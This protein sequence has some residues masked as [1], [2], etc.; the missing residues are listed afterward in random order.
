MELKRKTSELIGLLKL[1]I[2]EGFEN[3]KEI[4]LKFKELVKLGYPEE[5]LKVKLRL[6][7]SEFEKQI[8]DKK[9][10]EIELENTTIMSYR[11]LQEIKETKRVFEY[12][13]GCV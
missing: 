4:N 11:T 10:L 13:E 3:K 7:R 12:F 2:I 1:H 9:A 6:K 5:L 8:E